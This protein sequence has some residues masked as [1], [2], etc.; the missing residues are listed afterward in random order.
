M[1]LK[2]TED[3]QR[4]E[5]ERRSKDLWKAYNPTNE[6]MEVGLN[7]RI[8]PEYWTF[9]A[10]EETIV[11]FYVLEMY[12]SKMIDKIIF[13]K[14]D[15]A[16]LAENEKRLGRGF[17]KM[18]VHT[19][20]MRF[21]SPLVKKMIGKKDQLM[22]ILVRGLYKEY[23][24]KDEDNGN[25]NRVSRESFATDPGVDSILGVS[26]PVR[27]PEAEIDL[28]EGLE[29]LSREKTTQEKREDALK[30]AREAKEAK[31]SKEEHGTQQ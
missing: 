24:I 5:A 8:S 25:M 2:K 15:M 30:K 10:K 9:K 17:N 23:G 3:I 28:T 22:K 20:Q 16:V 31:K 19:E 12:C 27:D 21:E 7:L 18:D 14:A 11:P 6:D 26:S 4:A 1:A 29:N 13:T